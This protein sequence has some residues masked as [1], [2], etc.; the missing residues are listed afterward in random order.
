LLLAYDLC[1]L[2]VGRLLHR[3]CSSVRA[4]MAPDEF[5]LVTALKQR[6]FVRSIEQGSGV[7]ASSPPGTLIN[8]YPT[9]V[10]FPAESSPHPVLW[11]HLERKVMC[12]VGTGNGS[13]THA[14]AHK[15]RYWG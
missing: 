13:N 7:S 10:V 2:Q 4:G 6:G 12:Q 14:T 15:L 11:T 8:S 3:A 5:I 9:F 1:P